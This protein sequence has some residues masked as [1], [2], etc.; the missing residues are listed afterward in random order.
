VELTVLFLA[1]AD[2][3]AKPTSSNTAALATGSAILAFAVLA[4]I[5]VGLSGRSKATLDLI[6]IQD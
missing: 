4:S 1:V 6:E 2:M 3:V 5:A